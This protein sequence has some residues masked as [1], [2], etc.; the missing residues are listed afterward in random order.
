VLR[1]VLEPRTVQSGLVG[2]LN[3]AMLSATTADSQGVT[4]DYRVGLS[5]AT[6]PPLEFEVYRSADATFD[7][8]DV[9][10]GSRAFGAGS[11]D[12]SV[13]EHVA[14]IPVDG[15]LPIDP[16]RPYVLVVANPNDAGATTDPTRTASFRTYTIGVVTHGGLMHTSWK[17]APP[18]ALQTAK[19]MQ[20]QGY[21]AVFPFN[22]TTD[23]RTAGRAARQGPKLA[24]QIDELA[25]KFPD[26]AVVDLHVIGHSEGSTI[27]GLAL[28]ILK[29]SASPQLQRGFIQDTMLDPHAANNNSPGQMSTTNSIFGGLARS[30]TES[31][32]ADAKD[33]A[34]FVPSNVDSAEV[35][36]QH[37][38]ASRMRGGG[39]YNLWGQVPVPNLGAHPVHYYNL[40]ATGATHSGRY[41]VALWYRNF[42][43]TTLRDQAPLV[44]EL[45]LEGQLD[46]ASPSTE[47]STSRVQERRDAN[48]G[49]VQDVDGDQPTFSGTAAPG[50]TVRLY[51]GPTAE[52]TRV[53]LLATTT[54]DADGAWALTTRLPL[55][56]GRYRAVV[57]SYSRDL[58]TR[59]AYAVVP[60][61]PMGR[62]VVGAGR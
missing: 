62:F 27:N 59:P 34:V 15:G 53:D 19:L 12:A 14:T 25:A 54:A 18:W 4:V 43:A 29:D 49:P 24:N 30:L 56:D 57:M 16:A 7:A 38:E 60:M 17:Y 26:S 6:S 10:I 46:D 45:R 51:V 42:V 44:Q 28:S 40:T 3:V 5:A 33:P 22:W 32:Q 11:P 61:A 36:Y 20:R 48:W 23:S 37:T 21:D 13:G 1:D 58:Q 8:S 55:P 47:P 2:P 50:S 9:L 52:L 31:F 39:D 41:G 35:F